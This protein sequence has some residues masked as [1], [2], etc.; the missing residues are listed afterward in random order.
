MGVT[1][2]VVLKVTRTTWNYTFLFAEMVFIHRFG[3][4][5]HHDCFLDLGEYRPRSGLYGLFFKLMIITLDLA[6]VYSERRK[7]EFNV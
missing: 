7:I 2:G 6:S 5:A 3:A 1:R 4:R